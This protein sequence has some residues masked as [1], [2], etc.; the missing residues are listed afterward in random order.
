[1]EIRSI[2][3]FSHPQGPL[4]AVARAAADARHMSS[5]AG[6]R[7][8]SVRLATPPFPTWL[9]DRTQALDLL[10]W[11]DEARIDYLALGPVRLDDGEGFLDL[12][13]RLLGARDALFASAE[14]A[15]RDGQ[16]DTGRVMRVAELVRELATLRDDGFAN[17]YFTATANCPP[18]SPFF[19]VAYHDGGSHEACFAIAAEAADVATTALRVATTITEARSTLVRAI[20]DE[21]A[22]LVRLGNSL[23]S[24]HGIPFTGI[25]FSL[26]PFPDETR[27][28]GRALEMLGVPS[29]GG[30]GSA[31]A[32]A[33]LADCVNRAEFPRCGFSGLMFPVLEDATLSRRA[34]E[35]LLTVSDLLL[36]SA[37]CGAGLDT[38][39]LPGDISVQEIAGM[40][41]D[42]AA[43]AVRADK[44]LTARLMPLPGLAAGDPVTFDFSYF[45]DSRVLGTKGVSPGGLLTAGERVALLPLGWRRKPV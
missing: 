7:L 17:L 42:V 25:D 20:E 24:R 5:A 8:Q 29:T 27:S 34:A 3:F 13:P 1:M 19:P 15:D 45:A 31:F 30:H 14:I 12:L 40:L 38:V 35:G 6:Y 16:I 21:A 41:L 33:F 44:P 36:Y 23:Q 2:T 26:A 4:D 22:N 43:L 39:P 9:A 10:S 18:G 32:A 28:V 11:C 37:V